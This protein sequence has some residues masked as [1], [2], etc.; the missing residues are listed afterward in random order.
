M[1]FAWRTTPSTSGY[2]LKNPVEEAS[3]LSALVRSSRF[4]SVP[5]GKSLSGFSVGLHLCPQRAD[6]SGALVRF[7]EGHVKGDHPRAIFTKHVEHPCKMGS[8]KRPLS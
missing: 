6:R 8:G 2:T 1:R 3:S 7:A 5:L 4:A